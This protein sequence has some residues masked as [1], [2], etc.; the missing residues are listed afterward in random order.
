MLAQPSH[1]ALSVA[2]L[3]AQFS[4]PSS[5]K[6]GEPPGFLA[7][8]AYVPLLAPLKRLQSLFRKRLFSHQ[9]SIERREMQHILF[10]QHDWDQQTLSRASSDLVEAVSRSKGPVQ[11]CDFLRLH[12]HGGW[13]NGELDPVICL[14]LRGLLTWALVGVEDPHNLHGTSFTL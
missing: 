4:R 1:F 5:S 13:Q 8:S 2:K 6:S 7:A 10:S 11:P 12:R 3:F 14:S 9:P